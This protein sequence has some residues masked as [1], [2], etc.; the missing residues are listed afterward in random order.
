M[1]CGERIETMQPIFTIHAGECLVGY[2]I[3]QHIRDES[4]KRVNVWIPPN[5]KYKDRF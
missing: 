5:V 1:L 4:G 3:E 2:H